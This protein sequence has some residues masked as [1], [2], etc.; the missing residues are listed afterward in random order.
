MK[1]FFLI[2]FFLFSHLLSN[3]INTDWGTC[4]LVITDYTKIESKKLISTIIETINEMNDEYGSID[5]N[6]FSIYIVGNINDYK[7]YSGGKVPNWSTGITK[8]NPDKIVI[9]GPKLAQISKFKFYK[10]LKHELN[11]I[12][13]NRLNNKNTIPQWFKEGFA[14]IIANQFSLKHK[15]ILS[16]NK[17][18]NSLLPIESLNRF[19]KINSSNSQLAYSQSYSMVVALQFY[20]GDEI[21]HEIINH[22]KL[23]KTFNE[24]I[25][26]ITGFDI[27][28]INVQLIN[29]I[30]TNYNWLILLDI[31]NMVFSILPLILIIGFIYMKYNNLKKI[32]KWEEEMDEL[33][34]V[35]EHD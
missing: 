19:N 6:K 35:E 18:K 17:W 22:I 12:Y 1:I 33:D 20:Y 28:Y 3:S 9:K 30:S 16:K 15:I 8:S 24:A 23:G 32:K 11:H 5:T 26:E 29:Y 14:S 34:K 31:P 7:K 4:E 25:L 13:I 21:I 27:N 2:Y 10:I